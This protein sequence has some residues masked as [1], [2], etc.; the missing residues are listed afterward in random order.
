MEFVCGV[1]VSLVVFV[2]CSF[3]KLVMVVCLI[4]L[5]GECMCYI[6][7]LYVVVP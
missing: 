2:L 1:I 6:V 4:S 5:D 7:V 3:C